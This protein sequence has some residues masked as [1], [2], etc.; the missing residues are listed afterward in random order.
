[1]DMCWNGQGSTIF[2]IFLIVSHCLKEKISQFFILC[3]ANWV[4]KLYM[5]PH[6]C[7][8]AAIGLGQ[9]WSIVNRNPT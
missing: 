2:H 6:I 3:V 5:S 7:A 1:M 9:K 8:S 4:V